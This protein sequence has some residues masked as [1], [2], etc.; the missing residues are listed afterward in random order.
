MQF[1]IHLPSEFLRQHWRMLLPEWSRPIASVLIVLQR[2]DCDLWERSPTTEQQKAHLRQR[3]LTLVFALSRQ[4]AVIGHLTDGFDPR[5]GLPI[6]SQAGLQL[7]D[8]AVIQAC[9]DYP[10]AHSHGCAV[11]LHPLWGSA[12]YPATIV[13][14]ADP[15]LVETVLKTLP[16][17]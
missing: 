10:I 13:S 5:S 7:D 14:S 11:I 6:F 2:C 1:S 16:P 8:V 4:L 9:L 15:A 12:V 17:G 3:F